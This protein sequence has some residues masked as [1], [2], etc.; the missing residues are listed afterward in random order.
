[1][2][3]GRAEPVGRFPAPR[4]DRLP[5]PPGAAASL[6]PGESTQAI[7]G[8]EQGRGAQ[9]LCHGQSLCIAATCGMPRK[10]LWSTAVPTART[11]WGSRP[12]R[13]PG[14]QRP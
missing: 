14:S 5:E 10:P 11:P 2:P 3:Q 4:E 13:G 9:S 8:G 6:G 1:M 7:T 12:S